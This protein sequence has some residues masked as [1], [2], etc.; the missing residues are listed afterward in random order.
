MYNFKIAYAQNMQD[1][2]IQQS[3]ENEFKFK[4]Y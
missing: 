2:V 4:V 3:K 1:A